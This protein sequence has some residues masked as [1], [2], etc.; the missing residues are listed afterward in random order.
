MGPR[1]STER[2]T[3]GHAPVA[4]ELGEE[5]TGSSLLFADALDHDPV[6]F[7]LTHELDERARDEA[8]R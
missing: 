2:T 7:A 8:E 3:G 6:G 1:A 5:T 4:R